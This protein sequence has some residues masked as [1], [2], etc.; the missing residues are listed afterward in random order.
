VFIINLRNKNNWLSE[1]SFNDQVGYYSNISS[2]NPISVINNRKRLLDLLDGNLILSQQKELLKYAHD[3]VEDIVLFECGGTFG[4]FINNFVG[5]LYADALSSEIKDMGKPALSMVVLDPVDISRFERTIIVGGKKFRIPLTSKDISDNSSSS[6]VEAPTENI[7]NELFSNIK[8]SFNDDMVSSA[9]LTKKK[10]EI[11]LRFDKMQNE[12]L[13]Y[14]NESNSLKEFSEKLL[15]NLMLNLTQ[16][17]IF[18]TLDQ[19]EKPWDFKGFLGNKNFYTAIDYVNSKLDSVFETETKMLSFSKDKF[20]F[21]FRIDD[22]SIL[23]KGSRITVDGNNDYQLLISD[24]SNKKVIYHLMD[25]NKKLKD[26]IDLKQIDD[27]TLLMQDGILYGLDYFMYNAIPIAPDE[28]RVLSGY[29]LA[30]A[31]RYNLE[32]GS[33]DVF[34]I[35]DIDL[36]NIPDEFMFPKVVKERNI[37]FYST[38][39]SSKSSP[40]LKTSSAISAILENLDSQYL[41]TAFKSMDFSSSNYCLK[42]PLF[43]EYGQK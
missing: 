4:Y 35:S 7:I 12:V 6:S 30:A 10:D 42:S 40:G 23:H 20:V 17:S 21:P 8:K 1:G 37:P 22:R 18:V 41:K 25:Q 43:K 9:V 24:L 16:N 38:G 13:L 27:V 5:I 31:L 36:E 26:I 28:Q 29:I 19:W 14:S 32:K 11:L 2:E 15:S 34:N 39:R 3:N 33:K